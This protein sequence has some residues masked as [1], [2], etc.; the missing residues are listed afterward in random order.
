ME[1]A[2]RKELP[3]DGGLNPAG[4]VPDRTKRDIAVG[5]SVQ[6]AELMLQI[7]E[8]TKVA[9]VRGI[10]SDG[11]SF[12]FFT[13]PIMDELA[14]QKGEYI[15]LRRINFSDVRMPMDGRERKKVVLASYSDVIG[16]IRFPAEMVGSSPEGRL[17]PGNFGRMVES[18]VPETINNPEKWITEI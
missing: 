17:T 1:R 12:Y 7:P 2:E 14:Y 15:D 4:I 9:I 3:L 13:F 11:E 8:G 16:F 5:W 6:L 18:L 10:D